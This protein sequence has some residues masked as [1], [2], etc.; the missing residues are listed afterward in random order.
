MGGQQFLLRKGW[1]TY[2]IAVTNGGFGLP[3]EWTGPMT[4]L[5]LA[6][7]PSQQVDV[8][9]DWMRAYQPSITSPAPRGAVWSLDP[10]TCYD[11]PSSPERGQVRCGLAPI[12]D[13]SFLPP[14][15]YHLTSTEGYEGSVALKRPSRPVLL[16][17]DEVGGAE[18]GAADP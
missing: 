14:G 8:S 18:Y 3:Q 9:I 6:I 4:G 5:R 7:S 15:S 12:C 13:L 16:D 10:D 17:P 11:A 1:N 2:N